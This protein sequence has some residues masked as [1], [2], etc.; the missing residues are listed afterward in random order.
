MR[1]E[2]KLARDLVGVFFFKVGLKGKSRLFKEGRRFKE[3][4]YE[5]IQ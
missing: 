2:I 4:V 3:V 1:F 5:I